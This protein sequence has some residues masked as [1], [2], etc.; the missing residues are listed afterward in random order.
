LQADIHDIPLKHLQR[1]ENALLRL[2]TLLESIECVGQSSNLSVLPILL[3]EQSQL[4][5]CMQLHHNWIALIEKQTPNL[6]V[7]YQQKKAMVLALL[8]H[9]LEQAVC[10]ETLF[11]HRKH[12]LQ[13]LLL[14]PVT[15]RRPASALKVA[16]ISGRIDLSI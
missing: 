9:I 10:L 11:T 1:W 3:A 5:A 16:A 14:H 12:E 7:C 13:Q 8:A 2:K 6:S 4:S 15:P